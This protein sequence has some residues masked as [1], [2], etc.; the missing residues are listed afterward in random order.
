MTGKTKKTILLSIAA[1]AF[2]AAF[3]GYTL[4]NKKH[5]S[6]QDTVA[7]ATITAAA[8]HQTFATDA[9]FAKTKFTGDEANKKVIQVQGAVTAIQKDQQG[10]TIILLKTSTDGAFINCTMEGKTGNINTGITI[11]L[12]GI[13]TGYNF[14]AA[15]GIPGDVIL[16]RC[17]LTK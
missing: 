11:V 14:D 2:A 4:Y 9:A 10:N 5:F 1:L 17:F 12:K 13:C 6:V 8:L 15:M 16:V 7:T 3:I